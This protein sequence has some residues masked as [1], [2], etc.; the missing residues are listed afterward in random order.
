MADEPDLEVE[1]LEPDPVE[2]VE[3]AEADE[4]EPQVDQ[5]T[6]VQEP[7]QQPEQQVQPSRGENRFQSLANKTTGLEAQLAETRRQLDEIRRERN[8]PVQRETP[9]QRQ[10]RYAL[11]TPEERLNE[12]L[13]EAQKGF[14]QQL[15]QV[16]FQTWEQSDRTAFQ[17]KAQVDPFVAKWLPKVE[18]YIAEERARG[19][20]PV[21]RDIVFAYLVGKAAL[22][23]RGSKQ[24][25]TQVAQAAR[26]VAN[27]RTRPVNSG[28]DSQAQ[29][30]RSNSLER[31][32]ENVEI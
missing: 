16:Q 15:H 9:E 29:R 12:T 24:G 14:Q 22:E 28:S 17:L 7:E 11:L 27:A 10:A 23:A 5:E 8:Q 32:L 3:T 13:Q 2:P 4:A 18:G 26:R 6:E 21:E 20:P 25:K 1:D 31:R 30:T 19:R